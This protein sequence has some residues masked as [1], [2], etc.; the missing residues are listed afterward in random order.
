MSLVAQDLPAEP[1]QSDERVQREARSISRLPL[2]LLLAGASVL[3]PG[4]AGRFQETWLGW[5]ELVP[6]KRMSL[7][8]VSVLAVRRGR[9]QQPAPNPT[10]VA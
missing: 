2:A 5:P 4:E 7:K 9:V 6:A 3:I 10:G 8:W 1:G